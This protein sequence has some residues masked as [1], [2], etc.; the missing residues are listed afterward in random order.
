[1][2]FLDRG[3]FGPRNREGAKPAQTVEQKK[4]EDKDGVTQVNGDFA[5]ENY[6]GIKGGL[7]ARQRSLIR[8]GHW[9]A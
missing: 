5:C 3:I 9:K 8:N 1:M 4:S 6:L 7:L 2:E